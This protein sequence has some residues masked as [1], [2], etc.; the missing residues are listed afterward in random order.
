MK[1]IIL[2]LMLVSSNTLACSTEQLEQ[3]V[4]MVMQ[5]HVVIT[6]SQ[7]L[8]RAKA[9]QSSW[10]ARL[11]L[12][13][14]DVADSTDTPGT[15]IQVEIPLFDRSHEIE[16][17]STRV[18]RDKQQDAILAEFMQ[19]MRSYCADQTRL[20][21]LDRQRQFYRDRLQYQQQRVDEGLEEA[22]SLWP[23]A[24]AVQQAEQSHEQHQD[25][26]SVEL[27]ALARQYGGTQW[28][29]LQALLA[30]RLN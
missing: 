25:Q 19:K 30:D 22:V 4:Q 17:I 10:K 18:D 5:N 2:G 1:A 3:A 16:L 24:K 9:K 6:S 23:H 14:A 13:Y 12:A 11:H 8:Y 20:T 28:Q 27:Y 21:Q 15:G 26:L 29:Q 7:Q